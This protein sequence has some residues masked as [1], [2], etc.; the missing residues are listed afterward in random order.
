M[1]VDVGG[2]GWMWVDV[3]GCGW[4]EA[5]LNHNSSCCY[6]YLLKNRLSVAT[7]RLLLLLW[8][9]LE[10]PNAMEEGE[11]LLYQ[12]VKSSASFQRVK[13]IITTNPSINLNA[14]NYLDVNHHTPPS[15]PTPKHLDVNH[16]SLHDLR[17]ACHRGLVQRHSVDLGCVQ[18][19][20]RL[21]A[22]TTGSWR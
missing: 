11:L 17:T 9:W 14:Q 20:P 15:T 13:A 10:R 18:Q 4:V 12:A 22:A 1:W 6:F 19:R 8:L 3:G 2:C 16:N 21:C 7:S 5:D